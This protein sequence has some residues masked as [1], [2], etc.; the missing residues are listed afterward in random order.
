MCIRPYIDTHPIDYALYRVYTYF[1]P[2]FVL[3][4]QVIYVFGY[5][6]LILKMYLENLKRRYVAICVW[7]I[8]YRPTPYRY[9]YYRYSNGQQFYIYTG[10]VNCERWPVD[11]LHGWFAGLTDPG[12]MCGG[13]R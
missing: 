5:F 13:E 10:Q 6:S 11:C 2:S 1:R 8:P 4:K 7:T 9:R 12:P 3:K